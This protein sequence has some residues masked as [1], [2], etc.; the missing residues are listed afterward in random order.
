MGFCDS[1]SAHGELTDKGI[2]EQVAVSN[3]SEHE[4]GDDNDDEDEAVENKLT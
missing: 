1:V 2:C 4:V 3:D